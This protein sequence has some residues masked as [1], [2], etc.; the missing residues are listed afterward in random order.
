MTELREGQLI[1]FVKAKKEQQEVASL[2]QERRFFG[3]QGEVKFQVHPKFYHYWGNR[4]GYD[5]WESEE[6]VREFLR[7]NEECRIKSHS[8][9]I[10]VGHGSLDKP[11]GFFKKP[12]FGT[13]YRKTYGKKDK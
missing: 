9:K 3:D 10:Q 6:F 11:I 4:L 8:N 7:D 5:C 2:R 13:K 12:I 1:D